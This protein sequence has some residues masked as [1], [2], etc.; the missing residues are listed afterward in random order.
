MA[1]PVFGTSTERLYDGLPEVYRT[2][3][4]AVD[5]D[6]DAT[7]G[8]PLL[9]F[10]ALV[11]D[12]ASE[13]EALI[14]RLDY[15]PGDLTVDPPRVANYYDLTIGP[16]VSLSGP[17]Q[18]RWN[19][20]PGEWVEVEH[21]LRAGTYRVD[22]ISALASPGAEA[23]VSVDAHTIGHYVSP[24]TFPVR[25]GQPVG[26]FL[27]DVTPPGHHTIRVTGTTG[28]VHV[29]GITVT[30]L[31]ATGE[32]T[33]D[34]V[35]PFA[36]EAAW[37]P[38]LAQLVG[39]RLNLANPVLAR[40]LAIANAAGGWRKGSRDAIAAAAGTVLTG[41][42]YVS[43]TV[44]PA[45]DPHKLTIT[46]IAAE[47]PSPAAVIAAIYAARANIAGVEFVHSY[48]AASWDTLEARYPTSDAWDAVPTSDQLDATV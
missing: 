23:D 46:T 16:G 4:A 41:S 39:V 17:P 14:D 1:R 35:D 18:P 28:S 6:P 42:A 32:D 11:G 5:T 36:A 40:R 31:T 22:V 34:L 19:V 10:L 37:L 27:I 44:D 47:T 29:Q 15:R 48:Y 8:Y 33:S 3:D 38:W 25:Y 43:V 21:V 20:A 7:S 13:I 12:Q 45:T 26:G 30:Q 9:R 24:D 2:A